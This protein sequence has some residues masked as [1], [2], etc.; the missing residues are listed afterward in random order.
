MKPWRAADTGATAAGKRT[1]IA[2]RMATASSTAPPCTRL[3]RTAAADRAPARNLR[4]RRGRPL[5]GGV[6]RQR[7]ELLALRLLDALRLLLRGL[8]PAAQEILGTAA[9]REAGTTFT[10]APRLAAGGPRSA[11][12][13]ADPA[14]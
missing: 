4:Q 14:G 10:H 12:G 11:G 7:R 5:R 13:R 2:A 6:Q 9:E 8:A 3:C 1:R